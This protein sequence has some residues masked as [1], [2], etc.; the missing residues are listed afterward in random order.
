MVIN[1]DV[2]LIYIVMVIFG[3]FAYAV[4][5]P[6]FLVR[7]IKQMARDG[8]I[9]IMLAENIP[10]LME[11]RIPIKDKDGKLLKDENGEVITQGFMG[12]LAS[13]IMF[14]LKCQ[15]NGLKGGMI[16][17]LMAG[18]G[19]GIEGG[20]PIDMMV[21]RIPKKWRWMAELASFF[22]AYQQATQQQRPQQPQENLNTSSPIKYNGG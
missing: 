20:S 5:I 14:N 2:L 6:Y 4:I 3:L 15:L 22:M 18:G 1:L 10:L 21:E 9:A 19:E 7:K 16:K 17:S 13:A 8:S 12:Y 11:V